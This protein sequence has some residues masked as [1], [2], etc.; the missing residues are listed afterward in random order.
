[1]G[2]KQ[3]AR[4]NRAEFNS[5]HTISVGRTAA[6]ALTVLLL[7]FSFTASADPVSVQN[8]ADLQQVIAAQQLQIDA[9]QRELTEQKELLQQLMQQIKNLNTQAEKKPSSVSIERAGKTTA[10]TVP[11]AESQQQEAAWPG[12]FGLFGSSTRLAIGGFA[13]LDVIH[14][15]DA[16]GAPCQFIT[17]TIPT[18]GGSMVNGA[19]GQTS[20]CVNTSRLTVESRTPIRSGELKTYFAMDLYGDALSTNPEPR[21]R[22]AYAQ[23]SI[24]AWGGEWLFG[25]TW[26]T[27]VDLEAWPDILDFEGPGSAIANRQPML[28]WSKNLSATTGFQ[29]ALESPGGG[30][31]DGADMLTAW[32]DL[33]G[34]LRWSLGSGGHL[35]AAGILRD[36]RASANDG[37]AETA[38]G[39]GIAGSGKVPLSAKNSIVFELSYGKG[40]G[41]YYND[42]PP[43]GIY[44][45]LT[46]K[47]KP[48]P[49]VAYYLGLEHAWNDTLS[50]SVLYS[51][52]EVDNLESQPDTAGKKS[53]YFSLNLIW[54][55]D[56][57]QMYGVE[58]LSGGRRDKGGA[59]GT[60]NRFQ[61]T[62]QFSF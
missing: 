11:V 21:I 30:T 19:G 17:A 13:R 44:D 6:P 43:N 8:E 37:P 7:G 47:L 51:A 58:F 9:Q 61:L 4:H 48:L 53:A 22:E 32:P 5:M 62:G 56:S 1:V 20:F 41:S 46:S 15:D 57:R 14:D 26:G 12:S 25:Q 34:N 59:E 39:W 24:P 2:R 36:L 52:L 38:L 42:G 28:R 54:R 31:V 55:P 35:R 18:D 49:L 45:P 40:V 23:V 10:T 27:Y 16:I 33:I 3:A 50:S 29:L 60:N